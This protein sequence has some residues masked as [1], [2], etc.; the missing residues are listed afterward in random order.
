MDPRPVEGFYLSSRWPKLLG[1]VR[2]M[3]AITA[4]ALGIA[5]WPRPSPLTPLL[6]GLYVI[7][8]VL[9][10]GG[11]LWGGAAPTLRMLVVDIGFFLISAWIYTGERLW[12]PS[13]FYVYLLI[14]AALRYGWREVWFV[15][16]VSMA[17]FL[18]V[19]P[20][21]TEA[22]M[23]L[24][25]LAGILACALALEKR[26]LLEKLSGASRETQYLRS[27]AHEAKEQERQRIANDFHDGPLQSF[28]SLQMRLEF[29]KQVMD[30]KPAAAKPELEQVQELL[31]QQVMDLRTWLRNLRPIQ[32]E[33]NFPAAVRRLVDEF[34]KDSGISTSV[35]CGEIRE[36][37]E[38]EQNIEILQ[39]VKEALTNAQKH[40]N[41]SRVNV[42]VEKV[43]GKLE[44]LIEDDG[45]GYPFAGRFSLDEM[46]TLGIGPLSIRRRVR[47]LGGELM[48]ESR[49]EAGSRLR[50]RI[51]A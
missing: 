1:G 35:F 40:S 16:V 7:Y 3:L 21:Q 24:L 5:V 41:A 47:Q 20:L 22:L 34:K 32:M 12:F 33:G 26:S 29:L 30:R 51:A 14:A 13:L 8:A 4:L 42:S 43:S 50:V 48:V 45:T 6:L 28:I 2:L 10:L 31:K 19:R 44:I 37:G 17:F 18:L 49:P 11:W 23:P 25:A 38:P 27:E 39:I 15:V 9:V 36:T 46:E